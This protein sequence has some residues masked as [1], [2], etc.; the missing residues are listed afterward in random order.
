MSKTH[1]IQ[2]TTEE[3]EVLLA[4]MNTAWCE[5]TLDGDCKDAEGLATLERLSNLLE[6]LKS[7]GSFQR[8]I[9]SGL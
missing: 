9:F 2:L 5:G 6:R 1:T 3:I 4:A 8:P 7:V